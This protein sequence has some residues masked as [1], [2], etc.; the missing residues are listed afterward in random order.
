MGAAFFWKPHVN[1]R[2]HLK[3]VGLRDAFQQAMEKAGMKLPCTLAWQDLDK[4][5]AMAAVLADDDNNPY[6]EL[7]ELIKKHEAIEVWAEY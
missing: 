5:K 7:V 6:S 1:N 3:Q 2:T 4:L